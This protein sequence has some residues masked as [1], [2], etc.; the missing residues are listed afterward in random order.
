MA[1][2]DLLAQRA[3][4]EPTAAGLPP[5]IDLESKFMFGG[6]GVYAR[7]RMFAILTGDRIALKLPPDAQ[8][9]ILKEKGAIHFHPMPGGSAMRQYVELPERLYNPEALLPWLGRSI[10]YALTL[11]LPEKKRRRRAW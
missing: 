9:I 3:L 7:G 2:E 5:G 6:M 10:E 8:A 4:I 11:P 1:K